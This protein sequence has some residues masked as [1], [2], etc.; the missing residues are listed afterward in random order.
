M[1]QWIRVARKSDIPTD[2]GYL[3]E[4]NGKEIALFKI[5][6]KI[7]AIYAICP[8]QG[9]PLAEGGVDGRQVTC[10]WHGWSFDVTSGVCTFNDSVKQPTFKVKE[11]GE[12]VYV[13]A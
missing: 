11:E 8:H 10:P 4:S 5:Q 12:D 1:P 2:T 6:D 3:V 13:E 7:H 9:G